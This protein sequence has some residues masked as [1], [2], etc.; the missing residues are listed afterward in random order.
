M[1]NIPVRQ[2]F[3]N[4]RQE[5]AP[6]LPKTFKKTLEIGCGAGGFSQ[7]YLTSAQENWGIEPD[8]NA[9]SI[10]APSFHKLIVGTYDQAASELP[11]QYFDL[12]V[13]NDVIEHM[14][15]HDAFLQQ[16]KKKMT[17]NAVIVGSIPNIRHFTAMVKLLLFK[18]WPYADDGILDRT[19]LR[20]FTEK[21]LRRAL[22]QNGYEIEA[23]FGIRSIVRQGVTGLSPAK[24]AAS[25]MLAALVV[26]GS[27]GYW[28]DTQYPQFAFRARS[29]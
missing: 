19:H 1:S 26:V 3:L 24:S 18:D 22:E 12:V 14:P 9:A 28:S 2:Y 10:G 4:L 25:R 15:D 13:C 11:E 7:T 16:I 20:F 23:M 17:R 29:V 6:L 8:R 21:S 27:F 5:V